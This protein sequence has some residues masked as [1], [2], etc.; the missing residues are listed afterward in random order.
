MHKNVKE[1]A[2]LGD[3]KWLKYFF[4][5]S[6][7]I[8]PTFEEYKEDYECASKVPGMIVPYQELTPLTDDQSLWDI[9]YWIKLKRDLMENFSVKRLEHMKKVARVIHADK[10]ARIN[11]ERAEAKTRKREAEERK[12]LLGESQGNGQTAAGQ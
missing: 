5:E 10:L 11:S 9:D 4:R 2:E 1:H 6:L 7:D 12:R 8:D 3:I